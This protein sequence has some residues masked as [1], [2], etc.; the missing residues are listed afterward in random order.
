MDRHG[1]DQCCPL[2]HTAGEFR[3]LFV[4]ES[5]KA[6]VFQK[7][8]HIICVFF[9]QCVI[10]FQPQDDILIYG[11]P[12]KEMVSLQHIADF[13]GSF[14][15]VILRGQ[16]PVE[17]FAR[18]RSK[19]ACDDGEQR[20]FADGT[21]L[22]TFAYILIIKSRIRSTRYFESMPREFDMTKISDRINR[23]LFER[24]IPK[25]RFAREVGV[26]RDLVCN[27]T[28]TSFAEESM[29]IPVLKSFAAYFDK[30]TYYFCNDY[31]K[32]IDTIDG[33]ELLKRFRGK[34]AVTQKIFADKLGVTTAMY[35]AYEEGKC[36]LPYQVY[37][38][39]HKLY[40]PFGEIC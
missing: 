16:P 4:L 6:V 13:Q 39:L 22:E 19:E 34:E 14:R 40:G 2:P 24:R 5:V 36:S 26:S 11:A 10:Q 38:R 9:C 18:F 28:R 7:L 30:D 17:D 3:G 20:G 37:L 23:E 1:A 21:Y 32:F 27:Y 8:F 31:H 33:M 35:K 25:A 29:Q 15:A 12:L